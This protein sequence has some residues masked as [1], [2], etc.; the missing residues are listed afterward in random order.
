MILLPRVLDFYNDPPPPS[1]SSFPFIQ[2]TNTQD[3]II[4][5]KFRIRIIIE[6]FDSIFSE[7]KRGFIQE[8]ASS[9]PSLPFPSRY[10]KYNIQRDLPSD[11]TKKKKAHPKQAEIKLPLR[12]TSSSKRN[13]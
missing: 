12:N 7:G 4:S 13:P 9:L 8:K 6:S 3:N 2:A 1:L 11:S 5:L 10:L